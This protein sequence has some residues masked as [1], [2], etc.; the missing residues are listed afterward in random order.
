MG[1]RL[2]MGLS[3]A[4]M[5]ALGASLLF[6]PQEIAAYATPAPGSLAILIVQIAGALYLGFAALNWTARANLIGGI[7]SRPVAL[8]NFFHFAVVSITLARSVL[9]GTSAA[10]LLPGLGLYAV[11]AIWF[12]VVLF[13]S[14]TSIRAKDE[15]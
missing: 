4:F 10:P 7:Y 9:A 1:T 8:A 12:A 11:F 15:A 3:A 14:P 6:F 5:A 13:T 2:L